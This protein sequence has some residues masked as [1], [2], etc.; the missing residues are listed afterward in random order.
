MMINKND[1][2][3]L[4]AQ[5]A[6][7]RTLITT[8][9]D[10]VELRAL[11]ISELENFIH[12]SQDGANKMNA[13]FYAVSKGCVNPSFSTDELSAL[14]ATAFKAI[15]EIATKVLAISQETSALTPR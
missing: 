15:D 4:Y 11:S 1:F 13:I 14:S 12:L 8:L 9:N 2:L 7:V 6:P 3:N 10:E 5:K